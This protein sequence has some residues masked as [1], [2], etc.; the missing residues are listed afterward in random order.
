MNILDQAYE[1]ELYLN[2]LILKNNLEYVYP[3]II[4]EENGEVIL[5]YNDDLYFTL[6]KNGSIFFDIYVMYNGTEIISP[7]DKE[8]LKIWEEVM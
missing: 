4:E 6:V 8:I 3:E 5:E 2:N 7:S 1:Y